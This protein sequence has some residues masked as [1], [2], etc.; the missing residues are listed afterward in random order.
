M[1]NGAIHLLFA[2]VFA[3]GLFSSFAAPPD[4]GWAQIWGDEFDGTATNTNQYGLNRI[5]GPLVCRGIT[6][7]ATTGGFRRMTR[8]GL[9][10]I[11]RL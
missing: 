2:L 8:I 4:P 1:K 7:A 5:I 11:P 6:A 3:G 10:M 9:L